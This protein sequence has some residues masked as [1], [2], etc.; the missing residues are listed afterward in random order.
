MLKLSLFLPYTSNQK[1]T[2]T[3]Q[4]NLF[5]KMHI[6]I[7][8][9][10]FPPHAFGGIG[11]YN[12]TLAR[13]LIQLGH[14]VTVVSRGSQDTTNVI[15]PLTHVQVA[16]VEY[17]DCLPNY[18]TLSKN[19]AWAKK[20][21]KIVE[22][23]DRDRP[24]SIIESAVWDFESI[25]ILAHRSSL[26]IPLVVR[27]VTPLLVAAKINNWQINQDLKLCVEMEQ[28]LVRHADAVVAISQSVQDTFI[29]AYQANPDDRW[30]VQL[31]GVQPWPSYTNITNYGELP[32][33]L[34]RGEIQILFLGRLEARKGIE[35]FLKALKLVLPKNSY[36]SVWIAGKDV[37]GWQEKSE[38]LLGRNIQAQVQFLG[39]V[40]EERRELLYANCDFLVFPSRYESFG[41]VALEAMVHGKPVIGA[42]AGAISEVVTDGESG[43]LF[44]PDSPTDL[45][46]KILLLVN[47]T[48]L[49]QQLGE[50]AKQ[51][52]QL[53]SARNMAKTSVNL[54]K[55][56]V[57]SSQELKSL[58][59]PI[60]EN[61]EV[62]VLKR[63]EELQSMKENMVLKT[64]GNAHPES[65]PDWSSKL[66]MRSDWNVT[67]PQ[68]IGWGWLNS[69]ANRVVVPKASK[70]IHS[71]LYNSMQMQTLVNRTLAS[72]HDRL[73]RNL[74]TSNQDFEHKLSQLEQK[75][76]DQVERRMKEEREK[77]DSE[78]L[79]LKTQLDN[80]SI[81][82]VDIKDEI[83]RIGDEVKEVKDSIK[84][85][86]R[87][88]S[89]TRI[90]LILE[91][92]VIRS[93][94]AY[95]SK[96]KNLKSPE[97]LNQQ[98][99]HHNQSNL[100]LNL[101]CGTDI[102]SDYINIDG[103]TL[104]G[105]DVV[106]DLNCLP[107]EHNT[108]SE[109]YASHVVE[110]MPEFELKNHI[111]PYW[112]SLLKSRGK[113]VIICPDAEHMVLEYSKGNFSW[114]SL[115]KIT[116]GAQD[117]SGNF[118]YNM[119]T[120]ESLSRIISNCGFQEIVC[121]RARLVNGFYEMEVC[122]VK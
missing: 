42:R 3:L 12:Q 91:S 92:E 76:F 27:L 90:Q 37:E 86:Q 30:S 104:P 81:P 13:E 25:G 95:Q 45:A 4:E 80:L 78:L 101:G 100:R 74:E 82:V 47:N 75:V 7:I 115:R 10:E 40:T 110:H 5:K 21:A 57:N 113:L 77:M 89:E 38:T 54:Y 50:G 29:S 28:E 73:K 59:H 52:V 97:I 65:T 84:D 119:F 62:E 16:I 23:I 105:I 109:I 103:R 48:K 85:I 24:I 121:T 117:F 55:S 70:F 56:L 8:S 11:T 108:I 72:E 6:L 26:K 33:D 34:H 32:Q 51:R 83:H 99:L 114:D 66:E 1:N 17:L 58:N 15:G 120:S 35:L 64:T 98:K 71:V 96:A 106:A 112:Y 19:L 94:F 87:I 14:D 39:T 2:Q 31:L 49:R 44:E 79:N 118:H 20:V 41:L 18:P 9:Q 36:V 53:L 60:I 111:L 93:E 107:F 68:I 69:I 102:I 63:K 116:Y 46:Q 43:I 122:A 88:L 67:K 22:K 61:F